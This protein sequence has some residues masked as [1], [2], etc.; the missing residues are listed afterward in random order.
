MLILG[1][2]MSP[3]SNTYYWAS[4]VLE[5]KDRFPKFRIVIKDRST[6]MRFFGLLLRPFNPGF[7]DFY[8]VTLGQTVYMPRWMHGTDNGA[9]IL[10]HEAV[11]I[12]DSI[13]FGLLYYL[14]YII[15]PIGPSFRAIWELRAYTETMQIEY[16]LYGHVKE[17]TI[18]FIAG[19]FTESS[20]L[21]MF[22]FPKT[23][24]KILRKRADRLIKTA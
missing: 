10:R 12:G 4:T 13:K 19:Q 9:K 6:L 20:Y 11:H 3:T 24:D 17:T 18:K 16:N 21:W 14:S 15:L 8:T 2:A 22:P 7:M 1:L 5:L 23:I